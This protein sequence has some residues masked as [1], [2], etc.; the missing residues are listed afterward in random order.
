ML[1][2]LYVFG[3]VN[4][5][6]PSQSDQRNHPEISVGATLTLERTVAGATFAPSKFS[7][8]KRSSAYGLR[9]LTEAVWPGRATVRRLP[10]S[11]QRGTKAARVCAMRERR[12]SQIA[13]T[14]ATVTGS[15]DFQAGEGHAAHC[16]VLI[17]RP[18]LLVA[19]GVRTKLELVHRTTPYPTPLPLLEFERPS[20]PVRLT[21][22]ATGFEKFTYRVALQCGATIFTM[23]M[24]GPRD[25]NKLITCFVAAYPNSAIST[26]I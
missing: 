11:V 22:S 5:S 14:S 12:R 25:H 10:S 19:T 13:A 6:I 9:W 20:S 21:G 8:K 1:S 16:R 2:Y 23:L 26:L 4:V 7:N 24:N 3:I 18:F 15:L 17:Q